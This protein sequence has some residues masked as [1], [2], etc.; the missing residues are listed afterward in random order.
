MVKLIMKPYVPQNLPLDKSIDWSELVTLIAKA[1]AS[2]SRFDGLLESIPNPA[3]LLSPLMTQEAVLSSK[4]EGTQ[5]TLV[6]VLKYEADPNS[7][8]QK[9]DDINEIQNYRKAM[10]YAI[11]Q[12]KTKPM[13][14]NLIKDVHNILLD[15]VRGENK[16]RGSFRT[17]QNWIGPEG[18]KIE[19]AR[20]VPPVPEQVPLSLDNWE[21]YIHFDEKDFIVQLAIVHAQFEIIH[22]FLDGNGRIGRILLPLFLYQK[23][24]LSTPMFYLSAYFEAN[25]QQYYK[26]LNLITETNEWND[27]IKYFLE[28]V[29]QQS[30]INCGKA[31]EI[32][33]LYEKLK[34]KITNLTRSRFSIKTLDAIFASPIFS[35]TT[36][37]ERTKISKP[38]AMRILSQLKD[39]NILEIIQTGSGRSPSIYCFKDLLQIVN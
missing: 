37:I 31:K 6:D 8:G 27:W 1:N 22:P 25:R 36:F 28:A 38:S 3:V 16:A 39:G 33:V 29:I 32:H 9:V 35:S 5:A 7:T 10:W 17:I 13:C 21:K 18:C 4:I 26:K 23:N 2:V 19:Q 11:D 20:Y 14:L 15:G 34:N 30:N 24:V 12:L